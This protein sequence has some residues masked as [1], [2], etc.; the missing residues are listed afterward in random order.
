M[1]K[2]TFFFSR[3]A[4]TSVLLRDQD[5]KYRYSRPECHI[6]WSYIGHEREVRSLLASLAQ[7]DVLCHDIQ[8]VSKRYRI[9]IWKEQLHLFIFYIYSCDSA[10]HQMSC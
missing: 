3:M 5:K 9:S 8:V 1:I 2:S 4:Q 7:G 10:N 6:F